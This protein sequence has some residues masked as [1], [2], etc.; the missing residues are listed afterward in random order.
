MRRTVVSVSVSLRN[1]D[2]AII[3]AALAARGIALTH[4]GGQILAWAAAYLTAPPPTPAACAPNEDDLFG[5]SQG[6]LD[7]RLDDF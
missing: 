7:A 4:G 2:A 3:A 1:P 6:D 5:M